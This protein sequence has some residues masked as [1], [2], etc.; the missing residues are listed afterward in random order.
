MSGKIFLDTN[1]FIYTQSAI[2]TVKREIC[3]SLI[4]EPNC[5]ASTQVLNEVCEENI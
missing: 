5:C 4:N 2:D 1:I 3:L